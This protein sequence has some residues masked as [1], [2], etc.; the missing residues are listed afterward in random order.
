MNFLEPADAD[1]ASRTLQRLARHNIS[2][3][4]LTGGLA[5]EWQMLA[6]GAQPVRRPLNDI[7]FL[8]DAFDRIPLSLAADLL[9]RH[10]HPG[11]PPGKT[12]LQA[13]DPRTSVRIDI[14]RAYGNEMARTRPIALAGI[15]LNIVA[16][17]DMLARHARLCCDLLAGQP[18]N[19]KF[20]RDFLRLLDGTSADAQA[21]AGL[22]PVW[23]EH[24]KPSHPGSLFDAVSALSSAIS[25]RA[26]L[27]IPSACS[28]NVLEVCPRC[29]ATPEF[30]LAPAQQ[31]LAHLGYC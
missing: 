13:V 4:A 14:F 12:L 6:R 18:V 10:V 26:D 27:L 23:Q 28:R 8:V 22:D 7:D 30:P 11:D 21:L 2:G 5:I 1:R 20:A 9:V 3:F 31:I 19:P 17:E 15:S 25:E 24:R 16:A 29:H